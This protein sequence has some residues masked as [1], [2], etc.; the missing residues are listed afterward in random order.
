MRHRSGSLLAT[1]SLC[2]ALVL[3]AT[4]SQAD[5]IFGLGNSTASDN[6]G[7]YTETGDLTATGHF[8]GGGPVVMDVETDTNLTVPAAGAARV[9]AESTLFTTVEFTPI[10]PDWLIIELNP[11][12]APG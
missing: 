3:T 8:L 7:A 5:I 10:G 12:I 1:L 4:P 9:E 11:Q 6:I 2:A